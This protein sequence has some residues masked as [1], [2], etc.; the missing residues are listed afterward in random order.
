MTRI[1]QVAVLLLIVAFCF[2]QMALAEDNHHFQARVAQERTGAVTDKT[3]PPP[4]KNLYAL[5]SGMSIIPTPTDTASNDVW[6]CFP[7]T[8]NANYADCS[9]IDEGGVVLGVPGY[10]LSFTNCDGDT[11]TSPPCG[12][13]YWFYEDDTADNTDDLVVS[14]TVKQGANYV[15]NTGNFDFGPNPFPAGS[16]IVISDDTN[17]GTL[18]AAGAGNGNCAGTLT[19]CVNPK[20]GVANVVVTTTVGTHHITQKFNVFLE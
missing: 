20:P 2:G 11:S 13:I 18:G 3:N 14:I 5:I 8:A 6:P 4:K 12:Q 15:L 17:F 10:T 1:F 7:N 19:T 9:N 16:I